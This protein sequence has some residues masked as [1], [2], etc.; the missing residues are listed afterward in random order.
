MIKRRR[1][2]QS[3]RMRVGV[4]TQRFDQ[5]NRVER[6]GSESGYGRVNTSVK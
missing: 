2:G 1:R 4:F 3:E 6:P 5:R